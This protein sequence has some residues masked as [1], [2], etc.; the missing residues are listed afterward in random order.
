MVKIYPTCLIKG[1]F[2]Y[3]HSTVNITSIK[4]DQVL[5]KGKL[6]LYRVS[7]KDNIKFNAD[8]I[9]YLLSFIKFIKKNRK[10]L[11]EFN[12]DKIILDLEINY[13]EQCNLE[14]DKNILKEIYKT[15]DDLYISCYNSAEDF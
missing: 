2:L 11:A 13:I 5:K 15:F 4:F 1:D 7:A 14:F 8:Y 6:V 12:Y 3:T 9:D 10:N